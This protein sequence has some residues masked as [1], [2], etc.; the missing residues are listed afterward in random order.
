MLHAPTTDVFAALASARRRLGLTRLQIA[1]GR[2]ALVGVIAGTLL[3]VAGRFVTV[4]YVFLLATVCLLVGV[5][6]GAVYGVRSWP[7]LPEVAGIADRHF[8]LQDRLATALDLRASTG[9]FAV[10]QRRETAAR[11]NAVELG[12]SIQWKVRR[13]DGALAGTAVLLLVAALLPLGSG[14]S[15]GAESTSSADAAHIRAT[16]SAIPTFIHQVER[17]LTPQE[18]RDPAIR[19]LE[20]LLLRLKQQLLHTGNRVAALRAISAT[21]EELHDLVRTLHPASAAD[22][23]QLTQSLKTQLTPTE[24]VGAAAAR[25]RAASDAAALKRLAAGL[26]AMSPAQRAALARSLARAA[27]SSS[28]VN[29]RDSLS[30]AASATAQNNTSGASESL[31]QASRL[32]QDPAG[33]QRDRTSFTAAQAKLDRLKNAI[34][35]LDRSH[36]S[37][38]RQSRRGRP[39]GNGRQIRPT[40]RRVPG[41]GTGSGHHVKPGSS[42][43]EGTTQGILTGS[44]QGKHPGG[45]GG[46]GTGGSGGGGNQGQT[47][48]SGTSRYITVYVRG[49]VGSGPRTSRSV[50]PGAPLRNG[51]IVPYTEVVAGYNRVAR[52]ALERGTLPPSLQSYVRQYFSV[53]SH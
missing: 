53:V 11:L 47:S 34:S 42:S 7:E 3:L 35:G 22:L 1:V 18:R 14:T 20:R 31:K 51:R 2:G 4:P 12:R 8:D 52:T 50:L 41:Q 9:A 21:Q 23:S 17:G 32:L 39:A 27:S 30:Q 19:R 10:L 25:T 44:A 49:H 46:N 38:S 33:A 24:R 36:R 29:L 6:V 15:S 26:Q 5:V 43:Q 40:G 13:W 16:A 28:S 37:R 48:T 45:A